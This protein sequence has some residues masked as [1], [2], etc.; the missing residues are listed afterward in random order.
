MSY[1]DFKVMGR[2]ALEDYLLKPDN[3]ETLIVSITDVGAPIAGDDCTADNI[4]FLRLQFNDCEV[5]TKWETAMS[6]EQGEEVAK[7]I[8]GWINKTYV[9]KII[10]QC[11]AGC[12]RSAGVCAAIMKYL[13]GDDMPIFRSPKYSPNMNCYRMVYNALF[14]STPDETELKEKAKISDAM[15]FADGSEW[16]YFGGKV[17][18]E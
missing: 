13:T 18:R 9:E 15:Y 11:E 7:F 1:P 10:V 6:N 4:H 14:N 3:V 17:I 8:K 2:Y 16:D 5:S 12:S